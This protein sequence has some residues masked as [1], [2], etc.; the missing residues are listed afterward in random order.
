M[1][2]LD[3]NNLPE[4]IRSQ[5]PFDLTVPQ[6][7][8]TTHNQLTNNRFTFFL[9]RCPS[10]TH[11]CQRV[12]LPSLSFGTSIQENPTGIEIRRP[13]T[14][15]ALEEVNVGFIVD[16]YMKTWLEIYNWM[17]S[18]AIYE[19]NYEVLQEKDKVSEAYLIITNSA[20]VP[21]VSVALH[22]LYPV[23]LSSIDFDV[24]VLDTD[25]ILANVTFS[26]T[27]YDITVL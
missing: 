23:L 14:R 12:N 11:F 17:K 8:P 7:Q 6:I 16:E 4:S 26:F 19:N 1:P 5:L 10:M 22:N 24:S 27:H 21:I 3:Y 9:R 13:G 18:I 20:F 25:P 15:Y 2:D